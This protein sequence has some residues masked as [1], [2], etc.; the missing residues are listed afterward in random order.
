MA[1]INSTIQIR[2]LSVIGR[3]DLSIIYVL[4]VHV[5]MQCYQHDERENTRDKILVIKRR[6]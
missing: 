6:Q 5:E 4:S 3:K 2:I 1:V